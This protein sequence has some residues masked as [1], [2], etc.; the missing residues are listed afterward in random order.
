MLFRSMASVG[1]EM[2]AGWGAEAIAE[3][4][5]MLTG[6]IAEGLRGAPGVRISDERVRAPHLLCLEFPGGMPGGLV[7]RLASEDIHAASRIGR[8]R[9]SPHVYNDEEDADRFVAAFRRLTC[10]G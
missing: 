2:V 8:L 5:R 7:E 1:M 3:R 6:R 10:R 4:L 9:L